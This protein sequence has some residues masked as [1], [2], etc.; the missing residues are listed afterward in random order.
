MYPLTSKLAPFKKFRKSLS[1]FLDRL[2][3]SAAE[4]GPLWSTD[5]MDILKQWV[6]A[7]S[8]S[9]IRSFRHTATVI[10]LEIETALCRVAASLEKESDRV[11]RQREGDKKRKANSKSAGAKGKDLESKAEQLRERRMQVAAMLKE[12]FN[13]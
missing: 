7:M 3:S 1:E 12:F 10:A 11:G 8:S 2:V 4:M 9:Q 5:L 6:I 13:G